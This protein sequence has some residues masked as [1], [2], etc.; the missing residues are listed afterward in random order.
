MS[1]RIAAREPHAG[2]ADWH[3]NIVARGAGHIFQR[4]IE[5]IFRIYRFKRRTTIIRAF[6]ALGEMPSRAAQNCDIDLVLIVTHG[7][8][9]I[10]AGHAISLSVTTCH[11]MSY[12]RALPIGDFTE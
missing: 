4:A 7:P 11:L 2:R 5:L 10:Y 12:L 6:S 3:D 1:F 9:L 8:E